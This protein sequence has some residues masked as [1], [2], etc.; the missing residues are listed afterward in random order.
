[1]K[2]HCSEL[3]CVSTQWQIRSGIVTRLMTSFVSILSIVTWVN[4]SCWKHETKDQFRRPFLLQY[5][6]Y[7]HSLSF[8]QKYCIILICCNLKC[9]F[10]Q[11]GHPGPMPQYFDKWLLFH[12]MKSQLVCQMC[13]KNTSVLWINIFSDV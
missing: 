9:F 11:R 6:E 13:I 1:M 7:N 4:S 5:T 8:I 12:W 3:I 2:H 10:T